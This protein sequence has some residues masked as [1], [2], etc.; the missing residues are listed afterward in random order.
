MKKLY[1]L[2]FDGTLGDTR[3]LI[4]NTMQQTLQA[5]SLPSRTD[6]ECA[7]MIGLPLKQTFTHLIPMDDEMGERC[8]QTYNELFLRNNKAGCVPLFPHVASTIRQ[9]HARG[10]VLTIASSRGRDSLQAF[11]DDLGLGPYISYIVSAWDVKNAKPAPDMVLDIL[12]HTGIPAS[13][14]IVV[15]DTS[16][17]ILMAK[18]ASVTACGVT[19]GNGRREELVEAGADWVID[20]FADLCS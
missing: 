8:E 15:G 4:V 9:L 17:D 16:Y 3:Q 10:A 12:S 14:A 5:L 11:V 6:D 18:A 20:D 2:D 19:Y 13:E 1:I 7:A